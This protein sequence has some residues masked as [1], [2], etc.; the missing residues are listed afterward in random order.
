MSFTA[1]GVNPMSGGVFE[2]P[3]GYYDESD[4]QEYQIRFHMD[5][6]CLVSVVWS[7]FESSHEDIIREVNDYFLKHYG[8][9][10]D[11]RCLANTTEV[12]NRTERR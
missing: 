5:D 6:E 3:S 11:L 10:W 9:A 7:T 4:E 1:V 12:V 8:D 2:P